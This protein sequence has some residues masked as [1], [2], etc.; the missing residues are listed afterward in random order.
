MLDDKFEAKLLLLEVATG[1][2]PVVVPD[3]GNGLPPNTLVNAVRRSYA[4]SAVLEM[5]DG[6]LNGNFD[7]VQMERVLLVGL[8]CVH[9]DPESRPGIKD[10]INM[11]LNVGHPV[12]ETLV[13]S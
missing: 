4:Q 12:P 1:K 8:L 6:R 3:Q 7:R 10:A 11:L 13:C 5:A 9:E 2:E